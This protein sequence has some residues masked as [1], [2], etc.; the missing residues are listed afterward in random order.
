[1][2]EIGVGSDMISHIYYHRQVCSIDAMNYFSAFV[3]RK[4]NAIVTQ[5]EAQA[6][7]ITGFIATLIKIIGGRSNHYYKR[8]SWRRL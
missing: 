8:T 5:T 4:P 7:T 1:M 6:A 2:Q 3:N